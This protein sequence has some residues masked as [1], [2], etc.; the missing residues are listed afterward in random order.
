MNPKER[1]EETGGALQ[2]LSF[3]MLDELDHLNLHSGREAARDLNL[4]VFDMVDEMR[5]LIKS[6]VHNMK[7]LGLHGEIEEAMEMDS[8]LEV[9]RHCSIE[10][11]S[12]RRFIASLIPLIRLLETWSEIG[13]VR[14][15]EPGG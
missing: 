1:I 12:Y 14:M 3:N 10:P 11:E 6:L 9:V 15:E 5:K 8:M 2:V 13:P 7:Y 4:K